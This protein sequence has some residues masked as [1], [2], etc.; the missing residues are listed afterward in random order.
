[1][2]IACWAFQVNMLMQPA[3]HLVLSDGEMT[4]LI[5]FDLEKMIVSDFAAGAVLITFGAVLGKV[6]WT[7][8]FVLA[9]IELFFFGFNE[10][11]CVEFLH[12]VDCGGS[13][14]VHTFGAYFGVAASLFIN[15]Q[16]G[17]SGQYNKNCVGRYESEL[18][19]MIGTVFLW[20]FWPSFNGALAE[21]AQQQRVV[22][23]TVIAISASALIS[24]YIALMK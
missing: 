12:A 11:V 5:A 4:K 13:M 19:A 1:M 10:T 20:M 16:K 8:L 2:L 24:C 17:L 23:N 9:T 21:G 14:Y 18:I 15:K 7:Q 22:M 3:W 6:T